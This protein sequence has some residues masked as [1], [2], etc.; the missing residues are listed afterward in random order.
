M[1]S[2]ETDVSGAW[3]GVRLTSDRYPGISKW[4]GRGQALTVEGSKR[5]PSHRGELS[6]TACVCVCLS[7]FRCGGMITDP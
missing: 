7:V 2:D 5:R 4:Q 3:P 1:T 6:S